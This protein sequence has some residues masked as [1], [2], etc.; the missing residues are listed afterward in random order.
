[1]RCFVKITDRYAEEAQKYGCKQVVQ[2]FKREVEGHLSYEHNQ[3]DV[4]GFGEYLR[5]EHKNFRS[6]YIFKQFDINGEDIRCYVALR[7]FKRGDQEYERFISVNL[8]EAERDRITGV[9]LLDWDKYESEI[10]DELQEK[11]EITVLQQPTADEKAY[12]QRES[13]I[14][15][16]IFDTPI[17]ESKYWI[18]K[19][20]E[21]GFNDHYKVAD[22]ISQKIWDALDKDTYGILEIPYGEKNMV[23]LCA[24]PQHPN[25]DRWFLLTIGTKEEID[26]FK[27]KYNITLDIDSLNEMSRRAYP[28]SML[29]GDKDFWREMEIDK[30][31]NFILSNE[32]L[33]IVSQP[34]TFPLFLTGRAGSG[35][36]TMLQ[37]LYAD[38]FLRYLEFSGVKPPVYLSYSSNL[39]ENAKKLATNLFNKNHAYS[40]KLNE[41]NKTFADDI[42]PQF[43][44]VFYVFQHL[45]RKCI[46]ESVPGILQSRFLTSRYISFAKYKQEW[47]RKFGKEPRAW[48]EY[49]PAL[50]WHVIR[51]Y[52]KGWDAE[53]YLSPESYEEIGSNHKSVS[54]DVFAKV[55][56]RVWENWYQKVQEQEGWWDDQDLVRYCLAPDDD[57]CESCVSERFSAVFCDESQDFTRTEIEFILRLSSYSHRR[58]FDTNTLNQLPFIFAGD[59]FQTLNPTGFSWNSLR[60]YFTERLIHATSLSTTIGAPEPV[61]L[62]R[63]YR[64][65]APVVKLANRLQLL[66]QTRCGDEKKFTPQIPYYAEGNADS[67]YCLSPEN[68]LVWKKLTEMGV[69]LIIPCEEGQTPKEYI[70]KS[71][72]KDKIEFYEDGSPKNITIYNPIQAKGLEYPN[73]AVY[74]FDDLKELQLPQLLKWYKNPTEDSEAR[75]I[76]LKYFLSNAYV[77][78]TRAQ[79]K[80][81]ILANFDK[82]SFWSFAFSSEKSDLQDEI[83]AVEKLMLSRIKGDD[84]SALLGYI[85]RGDVDAITDENIVNMGDMA[86]S[87]EERAHSLLDAGLMR[88]AAARYREQGKHNDV[89]RCEAFAFRYE[90]KYFLAAEKFETISDF[91]NACKDYWSAGNDESLETI[92]KAVCKLKGKTDDFRIRYAEHAIKKATLNDL[93]QDLYDLEQKLNGTLDFKDEIMNDTKLWEYTLNAILLKIPTATPAQK[94]DIKVIIPIVEKLKSFGITINLAKIAHLAFAASALEDAVK[95]WGGF[96]P[97]DQP[98]EYHQAQCKL[99]SYPDNLMHREPSGDPSWQNQIVEDFRVNLNKELNARQRK[100]VANA[101]LQFGSLE[102]AK[103]HLAYLWAESSNLDD[104]KKL[105]SLAHDREISY[106]KECIDP[107][108]ALRWSDI[109]S[110]RVSQGIYQSSDLNSLLLTLTKI[111]SIK[112]S[113]FRKKIDDALGGPAKMF[114]ND[115]MDQELK[116]FSRQ[117]WN[118]LL[119]FEMGNL[120]EKRGYFIDAQRFYDW[121]QRH[122]DD[123]DLKREMIIRWI[124]CKERQAE[125]KGDAG[126]DLWREADEKRTE[127]GLDENFEIPQEAK[128][129]RWQWL[130]NEILNISPAKREKHSKRPEQPVAEKKQ[131]QRPVNTGVDFPP[132]AVS[133]IPEMLKPIPQLSESQKMLVEHALGVNQDADKKRFLQDILSSSEPKTAK[134]EKVEEPKNSSEEASTEHVQSKNKPNSIFTYE[135]HGYK[136]RYNPYKSELSICLD[137]EEEDLRVKIKN[138]KFPED[139]DFAIDNMKLLKSDNKQETPFDIIINDNAVCIVVRESQMSMTFPL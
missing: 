72:I 117:R 41:L 91:N 10:A 3:R 105:C 58:I 94:N 20:R 86:F 39:I 32:E 103:E 114:V 131:E 43:E 125:D 66:R 129:V 69:V 83:S 98:V 46:D 78:A 133:G 61:T 68:P 31:S 65:T 17:Y 40:K 33:E 6:I 51:T 115:F 22:A 122:T 92:L 60:S 67:V 16:E 128:F 54:N 62:T 44:N 97:K 116:E 73:V 9:N 101:L 1:M 25:T 18:D 15:Q 4:Y 29:E 47:E 104:A 102:E 130:F 7:V 49:G 108:F 111:K 138:G 59:E 89:S 106:A 8:A 63:N 11:P 57:V 42:K 12:I 21:N 26:E 81:F 84:A 107:L 14:T 74:G 30:D 118:W 132:P 139:A 112:T 109:G 99:L 79:Y 93:K 87:T 95:I 127:L 75:E 28:F 70:E 121:T 38:Y 64:S 113:T 19:I 76:E 24:R 124:A 100:I 110:C 56:E 137:S 52:I 36:S 123:Q 71:P 82:E 90:G 88:Q 80:L 120:M 134:V 77:S 35:K 45:V 27:E 96:A 23:I 85:V 136:F 50:S 53:E 37:Y 55:Y 119:F 34:I 5:K 126:S 48:R 13:G 2:R 135:L